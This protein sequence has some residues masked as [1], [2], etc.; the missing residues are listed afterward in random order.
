[1]I[2][3]IKIHI[4]RSKDSDSI[5]CNFVYFCVV[6]WLYEVYGKIE[7]FSVLVNFNIM[8]FYT[9]SHHKYTA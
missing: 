9:A 8:V 4:I 1:M 2:V 3:D 5:Y 7:D 6:E